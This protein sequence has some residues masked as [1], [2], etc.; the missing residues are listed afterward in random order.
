MIWVLTG[1]MGC[2]KSSVGRLAASLHTPGVTPVSFFDLDGE[3][4]ARQGRT[5]PEIF[6]EDGEAGFRAIERSTLAELIRESKP[7]TLISLGGGTLTDPESREIVRKHCKCIYLRAS[8]ETLA[9]N[10][11]HEGEAESRPML[12]GADPNAPAESPNSLESR[13]SDLMANRTAIY[14]SAA[15][16]IIDIDGLECPDMARMLLK[17]LSL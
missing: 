9:V 16:V 6:A 11:R 2:G 1:F 12:K 17:S 10:L 14:E 4:V 7:A 15:D 5:I 13:I 3:I 8:V